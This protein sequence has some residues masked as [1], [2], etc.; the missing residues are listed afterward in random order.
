MKLKEQK[1]T[2]LISDDNKSNI[3]ILMNVL[4]D[5]FDVIPTLDGQTAI[6]IL[7][8]KKIDLILLDVI[9]PEMDGFTTCTIIKKNPKT[10]HIPILFLTSKGEAKD[11]Q[12]GFDLGA[13]DYI[14]KPFNPSELL[15]RDRTFILQK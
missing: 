6:N 13:V 11:I 4:G 14:T 8:K 12:K 9:M 10:S 1:T 2:I 3:K 15:I 7:K 5:E